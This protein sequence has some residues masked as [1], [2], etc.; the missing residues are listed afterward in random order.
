MNNKR[1][2]FRHINY[3]REYFLTISFITFRVLWYSVYMKYITFPDLRSTNVRNIFS[4]NTFK[5]FYL[6]PI[7][8]SVATSETK[9]A[10]KVFIV[11]LNVGNEVFRT[12]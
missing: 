3:S 12:L 9:N 5:L 8:F 1:Y 10:I 6:F 7:L 4:K 2:N 11:Y